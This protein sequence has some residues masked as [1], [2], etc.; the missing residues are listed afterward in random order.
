[1]GGRQAVLAK[2]KEVYDEGNALGAD[3]DEKVGNNQQ[4]VPP[5]VKK[6]IV[7][8]HEDWQFA[9]ELATYL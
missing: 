8:A 1:M 7:K 3:Y 9:A 6:L 4:N 5:E 2:A